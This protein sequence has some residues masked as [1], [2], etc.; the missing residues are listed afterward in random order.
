MYFYDSLPVIFLNKGD[1]VVMAV[2]YFVISKPSGGCYPIGV[3]ARKGR[4]Y[5]EDIPKKGTLAVHLSQRH[6]MNW[7]A[8]DLVRTVDW[9]ELTQ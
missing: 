3:G 1:E 5:R 7:W 8:G 4:L 2:E 9:F 6:W